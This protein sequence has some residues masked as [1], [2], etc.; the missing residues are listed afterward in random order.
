MGSTVFR[1]PWALSSALAVLG[2]LQPRAL[3]FLNTVD[4]LDTVSNC[5][6]VHVFSRH[7]VQY[8]YSVDIHVHVSLSIR[9]CSCFAHNLVHFCLHIWIGLLQIAKCQCCRPQHQYSCIKPAH[10]VYNRYSWPKHYNGLFPRCVCLKWSMTFIIF[11]G[12][13]FSADS[14]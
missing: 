11:H 7:N 3:G 9:F 1:N 5:Y 6:T 14:N 2:T 8:M 13:I 10:T 4:P 12:Q